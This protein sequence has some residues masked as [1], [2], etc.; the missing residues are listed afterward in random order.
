MEWDPKEADTGDII[1]RRG[2]A[3]SGGG[4]LGGLGSILGGGKAKGGLAG[5]VIALVAAFLIPALSGG[6]GG[7]GIDLSG[8]GLDN[9]PGL[10]GMEAMPANG[11]AADVSIDPASDPDRELKEFANVVVTDSNDFWEE[12]FAA[13]KIPY[14]RTKMVLFSGAV[15][16]GCGSADS[17]MG[18]FYCP[19]DKLVYIDLSFFEEL[20]SRFGAPGDFAQAYVI[21]HEV[22]HHVQNELGVMDQV[23]KAEQRDPGARSGAT[24]LS[25]RTELQADCFAG[26]WAHS[27]YERG[28]ADP[29]KRLD[30]GDIEEALS[31]AE[32]VGDDTLQR[33]ATGRVNPEGFSHGTAE[34]RQK[35]FTT[36]YDSGDPDRCDTFSA[37][38]LG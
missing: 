26:V 31:A 4:G 35:W 27:R 12:Q 37:D 18:P 15:R 20:A 28:Q 32:G 10:D 16:S 8:L 30:D 22:G 13:A 3:S 25:V 23:A 11:D 38:R 24:G 5:V 17:A 1:D 36:G 7:S 29:T 9:L 19:A 34:Q 2:A 14:D 21:A 33:Q 6:G